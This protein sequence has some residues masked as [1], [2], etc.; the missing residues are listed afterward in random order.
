MRRA[1]LLF[2]KPIKQCLTDYA[3]STV[4]GFNDERLATFLENLNGV[5]QAGGNRPLSYADY[6]IT[7]MDQSWRM[8]KVAEDLK[9]ALSH[10]FAFFS[11]AN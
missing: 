3:K 8:E 1:H 7:E 4:H 2:Q 6:Q 5:I 10:E 9:W 11:P